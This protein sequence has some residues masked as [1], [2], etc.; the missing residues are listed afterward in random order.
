MPE[1]KPSPRSQVKGLSQGE[2]WPAVPGLLRGQ[3]LTVVAFSNI[4]IISDLD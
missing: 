4:E 3:E 2:Q 1:Q